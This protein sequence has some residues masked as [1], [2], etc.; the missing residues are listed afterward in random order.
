MLK[1]F[2]LIQQHFERTESQK[3]RPAHLVDRT[4]SRLDGFQHS[5]HNANCVDVHLHWWVVR[6]PC[7][8]H[9]GH[10]DWLHWRVQRGINGPTDA[11]RGVYYISCL[12]PSS[13][14]VHL[15]IQI[16]L[17]SGL[18]LLLRSFHAVPCH[19]APKFHQLQHGLLRSRFALGNFLRMLCQL[20]SLRD[21]YTFSTNGVPVYLRLL[22]SLWNIRAY[23]ADLSYHY[24]HDRDELH[25]KSPNQHGRNFH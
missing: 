20:Q 3:L 18:Y 23:F 9:G 15:D 10:K 14:H 1:F 5:Y 12:D 13:H 16:S 24:Y 19:P 8:L 4:Q 17:P 22:H 2:Y 7:L 11:L 21:Y 6:W 25:L